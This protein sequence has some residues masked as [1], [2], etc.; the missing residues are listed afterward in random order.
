MPS[1]EHIPLQY[2]W[3]ENK[4][5]ETWRERKID[6]ASMYDFD[7]ETAIHQ[8][9][10]RNGESRWASFGLIENRVYHVVWTE[11]GDRVRIISLRKANASEVRR[12]V[13]AITQHCD[14]HSGGG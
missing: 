3:D 10:D 13:E 4:R 2:E 9:S 5:D 8:R 1:Y 12:Y 6:F 14:S 7:W 11:R